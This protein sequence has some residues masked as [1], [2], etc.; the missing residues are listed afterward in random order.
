MEK[1]DL[2]EYSTELNYNYAKKGAEDS[3][4]LNLEN[5]I[6]IS[7]SDRENKI[8]IKDYENIVMKIDN[9]T[10]TE[11]KT[12]KQL[13]ENLIYLECKVPL[14]KVDRKIKKSNEENKNQ[15]QNQNKEEE[16][17]IPEKENIFYDTFK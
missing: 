5:S 13:K 15:K 3:S 17:M 2:L 16:Q 9:I 14:F 7:N 1:A 8:N 6:N 4:I 10:I 12:F 11:E